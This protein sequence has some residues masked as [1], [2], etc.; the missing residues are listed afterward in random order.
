MV[1]VLKHKTSKSC[2]NSFPKLPPHEERGAEIPIEFELEERTVTT[3]GRTPAASAALC[4]TTTTLVLPFSVISRRHCELYVEAGE[5]WIHDMSSNGCFVNDISLKKTKR[6]LR[7]K[8]VVT[9]HKG[10]VR[11]D[12]V[13][14]FEATSPPSAKKHR[15]VASAQAVSTDALRRRLD[16]SEAENDELRQHAGAARELSAALDE[17]KALEARRAQA[18][19]TL[20]AEIAVTAAHQAAVEKISLERDDER[21]RAT[22]AERRFEAAEARTGPLE[23][24]L[25]ARTQALAVSRE[26]ARALREQLA[27]AHAELA[28]IERARARFETEA[29]AAR[30]DLDDA[31]RATRDAEDRAA[32][33]DAEA[34]RLLACI[35]AQDA[36]FAAATAS[37]AS[38]QIE[39]ARAAEIDLADARATAESART[40]ATAD[41]DGLALQNQAL[42]DENAALN[43]KSHDD[44]R[45][46][47]SARE[48]LA[49]RE[50]AARDSAARIETSRA[51]ARDAE[52]QRDRL[53]AHLQALAAS[54]ASLRADNAALC[55]VNT[56]IKEKSRTLLEELADLKANVDHVLQIAAPIAEQDPNGLDD[57]QR[58]R[59]SDVSVDATDLRGL[60]DDDDDDDDVPNHD[61]RRSKKAA[62]I[63]RG[64]DEPNRQQA[65]DHD[66][67]HTA[68][69][70]DTADADHHDWGDDAAAP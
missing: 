2:P 25:D 21:C 23:T 4:S 63:S 11:V 5:P 57:T 56:T 49:S 31:R 40:R 70:Y 62:C 24:A 13:I 36:R 60:D 22:R 20:E 46:L 42:R 9:F 32:R 50:R 6:K 53:S 61:N 14:V 54:N 27:A 12:Y 66:L 64:D 41:V 3:V 43:L 67:S 29:T 47:A 15:T 69:E 17:R 18:V 58:W 19:D 35:R 68:Q 1:W 51:A 26:D 52:G 48:E 55:R 59:S 45:A 34:V 10:V 37:H 44:A 7:D 39:A 8:D 28:A 30:R 38:L 16:R 33:A 65:D